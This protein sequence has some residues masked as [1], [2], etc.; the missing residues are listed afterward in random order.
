MVEEK[1][2]KKLGKTADESVVNAL[3]EENEDLKKQVE[4]FKLQQGKAV[5]EVSGDGPTLLT[6]APADTAA[7]VEDVALDQTL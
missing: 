1:K 6:A 5:E 2:Q 7:K 3:R 4:Q